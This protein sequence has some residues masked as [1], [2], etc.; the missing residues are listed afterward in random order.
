MSSEAD[1]HRLETN[2]TKLA[3]ETNEGRGILFVVSSPSGGGKG[4]LIQRVLQQVPNLSYSVSFTTRAPRNG[5]VNGREYFF[6]STEM[7]ESMVAAGDFLEW[8]HV[9][10]KLYG[11]ARQQVVR[12]ISEGHDIILEVD[13]QGAASVRAMM[14]DSV[15]IFILPPS[16][17]VLKQRLQ[18][19][20]TDSAEELVLR[21]RNAPMELKDYLAFQYV[22]L[23]DDLDR[24]VN[25]MTAIVHAERARLSRQAAK[26]RRVVEAFTV[27]EIPDSQAG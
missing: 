25:Q 17:K 27:D 18:A 5:E 20:G 19:R 7:F 1:E 16:F 3:T 13:V 12:E 6:V 15:S 24:A 4:T 14:A 8:A 21:L 10:S 23:N 11:T 2:I 26:V 9:H 22:I